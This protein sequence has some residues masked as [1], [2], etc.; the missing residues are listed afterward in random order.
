MRTDY[1]KLWVLAI[2]MKTKFRGIANRELLVIQGER[3][4]EWSPFVEYGDQEASVW[5]K[6]AF[7][8]ANDPL[9]KI[10]RDQ[11]PTNATLPAVAPEQVAQLLQGFEKFNTVKIKVAEK[12]QSLAQDIARVTMV[13][14]LYPHAKLRLDANGGYDLETAIRLCDALDDLPIEYLEQPVASIEELSE[15]RAWL[16]GHFLIAA[17]ESIRK[18]MDPQAV[19]SAEAAD[20]LVLK[21]QPLGG[22]EA[23]LEI[24]NLGLDVVVSSA[25]ESSLG[26]SQGAYL[27]AALPELKYDCGLG[28]L[29]LL[30]GDVTEQPLRPI[31][32][33]IPVREPEVSFAML[34]KFQAPADRV[35]WWQE[36]FQRCLELL[37]P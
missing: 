19:I 13:H 11:I 3:F 17:D 9:P 16:K 20:I 29:N 15:F 18:T 33:M 5:L 32:S 36:R 10:N 12:G 37:K 6:A 34:E 21:A 30:L 35:L 7:G 31:D 2:P 22:I 14:N 25:L 28:T 23:A 8:F 24:A 4:S 26:I 1:E 27:A